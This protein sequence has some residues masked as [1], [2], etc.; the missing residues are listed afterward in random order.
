MEQTD[1]C[2]RG[3]WRRGLIERR[4]RDQSKNIHVGL[5][6]TDNS[7]GIDYQSG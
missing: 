4:G 2:K 7:V 6:V 1:S 5:M 3:G